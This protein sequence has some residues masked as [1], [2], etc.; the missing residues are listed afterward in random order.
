MKIAGT[1]D[2]FTVCIHVYIYLVRLISTW[3]YALTTLAVIVFTHTIITSNEE[4]LDK[5]NVTMG[6]VIPVM[7]SCVFL[8]LLFGSCCVCYGII[9]RRA[10]HL[11]SGDRILLWLS[12]DIFINGMGTNWLANWLGVPE[13]WPIRITL[14]IFWCIHTITTAISLTLIGRRVYVRC[15]RCSRRSR[16]TEEEQISLLTMTKIPTI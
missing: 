5:I 13:G 4:L 8:V 11:T 2:R 9:A 16:D 1:V 3:I 6:V 15:I 7:W 14:L 10:P 12:L